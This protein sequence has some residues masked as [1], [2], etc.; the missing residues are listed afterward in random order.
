MAGRSGALEGGQSRKYRSGRYL[1]EVVAG[2]IRR[3][4]ITNEKQTQTSGQKAKA[5]TAD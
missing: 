4:E 3:D 1:K 5:R 2:A